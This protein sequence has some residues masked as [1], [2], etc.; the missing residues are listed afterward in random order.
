MTAK[1]PDN[2]APSGKDSQRTATRQRRSTDRLLPFA[3]SRSV[4][5]HAVFCAGIAMFT[6]VLL[7]LAGGSV[8]VAAALA[9]FVGALVLV[10]AG[11]LVL[12]AAHAH[13][14]RARLPAAFCTGVMLVSL[15]MLP[16]VWFANVTAATAFVVVGTAVAACGFFKR[17]RT[18]N[19]TSA[20]S[21]AAW[22]DVVVTL[23]LAALVCWFGRYAAGALPHLIATGTLPAS[24]DYF[25]HA[26]VVAKFGDPLAVGP[27]DIGMFGSPRAF[28]HY[29]FFMLAAAL[30]PL[31]GT[32]ALGLATAALLPIGLLVGVLGLYVFAT[33]LGGRRIGMFAAL[34][35][36]CLP[37]A[38]HYWLKNWFYGFHWLLFAAPGSGYAT[39]IGLVALALAVRW[40]SARPREAS[41]RWPLLAMCMTFSLVMFRAHMFLLQAP[42]LFALITLTAWPRLR[43][44]LIVI[45]VMTLAAVAALLAFNTHVRDIWLHF[46][47]TPQFLDLMLKQFAT[48][49][50]AATYTNLLSQYG[51]VATSIIGLAM[52]TVA[53]LGVFLPVYAA[54]GAL[55]ARRHAFHIRD[56]LPLLML[57][58][59]LLLIVFAPVAYNGDS[60]EYKQ[61]HFV[62]LYAVF[63][64]YAVCLL[65]RL[66]NIGTHRGL[67]LPLRAQ[68]IAFVLIALGCAVSASGFN[69]AKP[70]SGGGETFYEVPVNRD[71]VDAAQ[72]IR[73]HSVVGDTFAIGGPDSNQLIL[74]SATVLTS[75]TDLPAY[76]SRT[77]FQ[78]TLGGIKTRM[79]KER[80]AMIQSIDRAD[81][82]D[83]AQRLLRDAHVTWYVVPREHPVKSDP[84]G[85]HASYRNA[86]LFVYHV[87]PSTP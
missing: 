36:M 62:L 32:P 50:L 18:Q 68:S 73:Q 8:G 21:E 43:A 74:D 56:A 1:I 5:Q 49:A 85:E 17:R 9:A 30:L 77:A 23:T 63:G 40:T 66:F 64:V 4:S 33:E 55:L 31:A 7:H 28:Y 12:E 39:G 25:I 11:E 65:A 13:S 16:I 61:R 58:C 78:L 2:M 24:S 52:L 22:T 80:M 46:S 38:S 83:Q 29:G 59:Y 82:L 69:P 48:P 87:L 60:S 57:A 67:T 72:H 19:A 51:R 34:L 14:L 76:L 10:Q 6:L 54:A 70:S 44:C 41:W 42:A 45:V 79:A 71:L 47:Q 3:T 37:D 53:P 27:S 75:L 35:V 81:T 15:A 20:V 84:R 86:G 26:G